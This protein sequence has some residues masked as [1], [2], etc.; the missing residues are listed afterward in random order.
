MGVSREPLESAFLCFDSHGPA[1][2]I[3]HDELIQAICVLAKVQMGHQK[4][5]LAVLQPVANPAA[6]K[7]NHRF[8]LHHGFDSDKAEWFGP[9]RTEGD[10]FRALISAAK[11]ISC[12]PIQKF[13]FHS[14]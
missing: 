3:I 12:A 1:Q 6:I 8:A 14:A 11:V 4:S 5:R 10:N 2:S 7:S 13:D 9:N